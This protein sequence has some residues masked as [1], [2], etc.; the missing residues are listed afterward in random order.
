[1]K[2][3]SGWPWPPEAR[4]VNMTDHRPSLLWVSDIDLVSS[5]DK[6]TYLQT[7][8]HLCDLGWRVTLVTMRMEMPVADPRITIWCAP[9]HPAAFF[10]RWLIINVALVR[11]CAAAR[12]RPDVVLFHQYSGPFLLM[13]RLLLVWPPWRRPRLVMDTR[14]VVMT[15]KG[16]RTFAWK[17][18]YRLAYALADH[19]ADGQTAITERMVEHL[20]IPR[21]NLLGV[22]PSGVE[23][24]QFEKAPAARKWPGTVETVRFVYL[25]ALWSERNLLAACK[26]VRLA[27]SKGLDV[28]LD[29]VGSGPATEELKQ[30]AT[31]SPEARIRV[32]GPV[33]SSEVANVLASAH[34][35]I[36]PFPDL[37]KYRVSSF[38]KLLEYM[39]AGMPVLATRIVAHQDVIQDE[40]FAF[41]A[42]DA[43]VEALADA[44]RGA[45]DR[46][47]DLE[48]MGGAAHRAS[49]HWTYESTAGKLDASLRPLL[50]VSWTPRT[51]RWK[52]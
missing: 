2:K 24:R 7:A 6:A 46:R 18:W 43:S 17:S 20:R 48:R 50:A 10:L 8:S 51:H 31:E 49:R 11:R 22:W 21:K 3:R 45:C 25:G 40:D 16:F 14:S 5:L 52:M 15:E 30:F 29:L 19:L 32:Y 27:N 42:E 44:M 12:P 41:W 23:P 38:I 26:A 13:L 33:S 4:F 47:H 39:A 35:G 34:V 28:S 36:L 9:K 37:A 1:M